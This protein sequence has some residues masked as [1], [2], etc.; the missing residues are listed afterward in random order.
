MTGTPAIS[1][2]IA[3]RNPGEW[4]G[5]CVTSV[6]NQSLA[7][8]EL[9]IVDDGSDT[10]VG[11][12]MI[13]QQWRS[14]PRL[15]IDRIPHSGVSAARN[16]GVELARGHWIAFADDDDLWH[17]E[18]MSLLIRMAETTGA[19]A[20]VGRMHYSKLPEFRHIGSRRVALMSGQQA[21]MHALHQTAGFDN[22]VWAKLFSRKL[23]SPDVSFRPGR[24]E[25]LDIIY[26][27]YERAS[28]VVATRDTVYFYRRRP[29]SFINTFNPSRLDVLDVTER[30]KA[31]YAEASRALRGAAADRAFGAACNILMAI[32]N[33]GATMPEAER[34]CLAMIRGNR[35]SVALNPRVR[36][37]NKLGSL[38][39]F[40]W[41]GIF[42]T[43]GHFSRKP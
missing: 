8:L 13:P 6:L 24:Y 43:I 9:I 4:F 22:G 11:T 17:P 28:K 15:R 21:V 41:P 40:L 34:R 42:K 5:P 19:E 10:P 25:D 36:L 12:A 30:I 16:R 29:G 39:A 32:G 37:K 2:I 33:A 1:V 3:T 14:D 26:R 27:L 38:L 31:H 18:A 35:G 23:F 7:D 20:A